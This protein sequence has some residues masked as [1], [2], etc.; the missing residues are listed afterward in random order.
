MWQVCEPYRATSRTFDTKSGNNSKKLF[1]L[2]HDK[3][4]PSDQEDKKVA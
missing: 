1:K 2:I 4:S 3:E